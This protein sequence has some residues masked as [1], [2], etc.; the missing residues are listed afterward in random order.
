[1]DRADKDDVLYAMN[2][3]LYAY[4]DGVW[5][6]EGEQR[7]R[8]Y[9]QRALRSKYSAGIL[10]ELKE[11]TKHRRSFHPEELG[12]PDGTL[13]VENGLLDLLDGDLTELTRDHRAL[14]RAPVEYD[15]DATT[16]ETW[17]QFLDESIAD[18]TG[19]QKFQEY[20]GYTLWHHAQPFGKALFL[21]GPT[22]SGKGTA[23]KAVQTVLGDD[24][25]AHESLFD[26]IQTRWGP[27]NIHDKAANI[28][29]EVTPG[30]L[31][32]IQ[33][34]KELTGGEGRV[35]A[36]FK[37]QDKFQ[38][39]VT[40]KFLFA[41]N[42][43]PS[44]EDADEAFYNRCLFVRFPE[45]VPADDQDP[46]LDDKLRDEKAGI[47]NWML[48]GLRRLMAQGHFTGEREIG[49]KKE[50]CD[51]FG[52]PLD[53]FVHTCLDVTGDTGDMVAKSDLFDLAQE[54]ADAIDKEPDWNAQSGFT[55][56]LKGSTVG[57]GDGQTRKLGDGNTKVF[58]GVRLDDDHISGADTDVR[59][60]TRDD[61]EPTGQQ[62]LG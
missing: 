13:A 5:T 17:L 43:M 47:F 26:L 15:S 29:N 20:C 51:A 39:T 57:I 38:F 21:V 54:Y 23:L 30:G 6:T 31:S 34:F 32:N 45:T 10:D 9:G 36:E 12:A 52:S 48:E 46:H 40:Q 61:D 41:T 22:D 1:M 56:K 3:H 2:G 19:R 49:A 18:E 28:R 24:N 62:R 35:S 27:A 25:V 37:G 16:P 8:E 58:T 11:R 44:I 42:E 4:D 53:R 55:R 59:A 7:L 60:R 50:I 33:R 14:R